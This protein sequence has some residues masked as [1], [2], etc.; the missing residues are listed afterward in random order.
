VFIAHGAFVGREESWEDGGRFKNAN[1]RGKKGK[2]GKKGMEG[3]RGR[4]DLGQ[5]GEKS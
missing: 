1:I 2:K 3:Y 5:N 4:G